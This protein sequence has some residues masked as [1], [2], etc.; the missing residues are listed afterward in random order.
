VIDI[1]L[2]YIYTSGQTV[3]YFTYLELIIICGLANQLY[4]KYFKSTNILS[5]EY[6]LPLSDVNDFYTRSYLKMKDVLKTALDSMQNRNILQYIPTYII[7]FRTSNTSEEYEYREATIQEQTKI[8][9]LRYKALHDLNLKEMNELWYKPQ[10]IRQ[11][12]Y[13]LFQKYVT[14]YNPYW[15][16]VYKTTKI[17]APYPVIQKEANISSIK[18]SLNLKMFD[19]LN[20]QAIKE[21]A[22]HIAPNQDPASTEWVKAQQLL[23]NKLIKLFDDI[24]TS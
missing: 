3:F 7:I 6:I 5:K 16:K 14:S 18:Q 11:Q 10:H 19:F 12:F 2:S 17:L 1:I 24:Y 8:I 13:D 15:V 21:S 22:K 9:E 23:S 4:E 20:D